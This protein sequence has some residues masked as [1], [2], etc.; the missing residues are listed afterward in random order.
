MTAGVENINETVERASPAKSRFERGHKEIGGRKKGTPNLMMAILKSAAQLGGK[1]EVV[2]Y[3]KE[4]AQNRLCTF[5]KLLLQLTP[6]PSRPTRASS[7][8][9]G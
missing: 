2:S 3:F 9:F 4:L 8:P 7:R 1:D 6:K 5:G